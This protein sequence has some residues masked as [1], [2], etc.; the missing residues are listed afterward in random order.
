MH[1]ACPVAARE[2]T[3]FCLR[4]AVYASD[5]CRAILT[6]PVAFLSQADAFRRSETSVRRASALFYHRPGTL[7][8]VLDYWHLK[9]GLEVELTATVREMNGSLVEKERLTFDAAPVVNYRPKLARDGSVEI[10]AI[11]SSNLVI[12][13][14]AVMAVYETSDSLGLLHSYTRAYSP[15]E[16]GIAEG[17]ESGWTLRDRPG[18]RSFAYLH[19]GAS[20]WPAQRLQLRA[21]NAA[22][23]IR[24]GAKNLAALAPYQ[25]VRLEPRDFISGLESFLGG[26]AGHAS[27]TFRV[28]GCFPRMLVGNETDDGRELQVTH[29]N[30]NYTRHRT[31]TVP[32]GVGLFRVPRLGGTTKEVLVYPDATPGSYRASSGDRRVDFS[33]GTFLRWEDAREDIRFTRL[34]GDL[35]SRLVTALVLPTAKR[36]PVEMSSGIVHAA[37]EKKRMW[38]CPT[39]E[40]GRL[41]VLRHGDPTTETPLRLRLYSSRA[42]HCLERTLPY[43]GAFEDGVPTRDLFPG[44][45]A[46]L[47]GEL[48]Y[49]TLTSDY[50]GLLVFTLLESESGALGYEHSF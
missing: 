25:T 27:L 46:F 47:G 33:S 5:G 6:K 38:W 26:A 36:L 21:R 40:R 44:A 9:R 39:G 24:E 17:E 45:R 23:E 43:S 13:Y 1:T 14:A 34:D 32:G 20:A 49:L 10:E 31:D 16:A 2:I 42:S 50:P 3:R 48:G 37:F 28:G 4:P 41:V 15:G 7:Y 22:G 29:S 19:N 12:P 35:P 11:S 30:F 8:S 18:V